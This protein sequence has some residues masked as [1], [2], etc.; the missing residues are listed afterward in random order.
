M[1]PSELQ[2]TMKRVKMGVAKADEKWIKQ[3][4]NLVEPRKDS[5]AS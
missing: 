5:G 4:G 1:K 2:F 3:V